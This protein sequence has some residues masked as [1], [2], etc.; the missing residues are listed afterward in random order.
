[1]TGSSRRPGSK[2]V[3]DSASRAGDQVGDRTSVAVVHRAAA[4]RRDRGSVTAEFA[5]L[6]PGLMLLLAAILAAGTAA[7][8]QLRCLDAARS[9]ARLAARHE[10]PSAVVSA[11][12]SAAPSAASVQVQRT[13]DLVR[14]QV[15]ATVALPLPGRPGIR[16]AAESVA[17]LEPGPVE[18]ASP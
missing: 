13:G 9:A 10:P 1:M 5:V 12:R 2:Q 18:V 3:D 15:A 4:G 8:A 6:L 17:R 14:V 11:A 16:V 7:D